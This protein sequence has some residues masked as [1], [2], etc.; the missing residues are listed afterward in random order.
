MKTFLKIIEYEPAFPVRLVVFGDTHAGHKEFYREG[1]QRFL[2]SHA[3]YSNTWLLGMGDQ[4]ESIAPADVRRFQVSQMAA[5]ID[6]ILDYQIEDFASLLDAYQGRILGLVM[7]N[8]EYAI[9]KRYGTNPHCR[10]CKAL[11]TDDLGMSFLMRLVLK[12]KSANGKHLGSSRSVIIYGHHGWGGGSRTEGGNV[13]KYS[14]TIEHFLA[15]VFLFGHTHDYWVKKKP[16]ISVDAKGNVQHRDVLFA[17]AGT[18]KRTLSAS[19]MPTWEESRGLPPRLLGGLV[20]E[21]DIDHHKPWV[22]LRVVE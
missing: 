19:T 7:G 4:L 20:I 10:L 21:I 13:T 6:D 1:F 12:R 11:N 18:F 9:A 5:P 14:R 3:A 22:E 15:D 17:N 2:K 16:R 8:H